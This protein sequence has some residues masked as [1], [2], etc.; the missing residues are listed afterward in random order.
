MEELTTREN[1]SK[2]IYKGIVCILTGLFFGIGTLLCAYNESVSRTARYM[3]MFVD[4]GVGALIIGT[5]LVALWFSI[6][7]IKKGRESGDS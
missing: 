5:G 1:A 4:V 3:F 6:R 2:G 7:I